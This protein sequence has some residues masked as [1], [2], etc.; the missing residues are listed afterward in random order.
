MLS[1]WIS[2]LCKSLELNKS[3]LNKLSP[4]AESYPESLI[5]VGQEIQF[6]DV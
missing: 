5:Q 4:E 2:K 3:L 6:D 1:S